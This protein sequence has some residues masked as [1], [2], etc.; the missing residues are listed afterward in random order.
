M[1][2]LKKVKSEKLFRLHTHFQFEADR[3]HD[4]IKGVVKRHVWKTVQLME[5]RRKLLRVS[6]IYKLLSKPCLLSF[7]F[8]V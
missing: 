1:E 3:F 8:I 7:E 2:V 4:Q 5:F 6:Y